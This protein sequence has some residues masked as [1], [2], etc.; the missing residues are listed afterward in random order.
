MAYLRSGA[1]TKDKDANGN[2]TSEESYS[3]GK[4]PVAE[5]GRVERSM[6]SVIFVGLLIDLLAFT[7]ILPLFPALLDHYKKNDA[8]GGLYHALERNVK[9]FQDMLGA[10]D[11]F[12]SVLF[13]GLIGS[14]FS[15]LQFVASPVIGGMSDRFG[16]RPLLLVSTAGIAVSYAVW[17]SAA[18]FA[19]FV[20]ARVIGGLAKGNVSLATAIVTD[21]STPKTRGK[22]MALIGIA[23]SIGFIVGPLIGAF[24]S[25]WGR[26]R[27]D[28][29]FVYPAYCALALSLLDLAFLCAFF[30]ETLPE[31]KR[32]KSFSAAVKQALVYINPIS[33]FKFASLKNLSPSD[34][35]ALQ[36]QGLVYFLYLFLYSGLEF[37]LTFLTHIRLDST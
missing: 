35:A 18:S 26:E 17:A 23:F 15:F 11:R 8:P 34:H 4:K 14:L 28:N 2:S 3:N 30:K 5:S 37:T 13:G 19:M 32:L 25:I 9:V 22:G 20:V 7:L 10:P 21:E 6:T 1:N 24:F 36:T 31:Q 29:W 16:R 12:N 33:L 27:A